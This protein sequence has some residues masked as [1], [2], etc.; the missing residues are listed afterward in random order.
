MARPKR[1]EL[2][3]NLFG[4][5]ELGVD[6]ITCESAQ[7]PGVRPSDQL[8]DRSLPNPHQRRRLGQ[9]RRIPGARGDR[10]KFL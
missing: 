4:S 1:F 3:D 2:R 5:D 9:S 10:R 7:N 8:G 6:M